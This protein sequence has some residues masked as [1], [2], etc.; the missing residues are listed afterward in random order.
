M[1]PFLSGKLKAIK[2]FT[3]K[4]FGRIDSSPKTNLQI[5]LEFPHSTGLNKSFTASLAFD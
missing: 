4:F 1:K 5:E 3:K 2:I